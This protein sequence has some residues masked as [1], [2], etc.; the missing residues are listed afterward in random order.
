MKYLFGKDVF[1]YSTSISNEMLIPVRT[2]V[3]T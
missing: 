3:D 1:N 2:R